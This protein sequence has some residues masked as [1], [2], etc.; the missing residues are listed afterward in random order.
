MCQIHGRALLLA[1]SHRL[2]LPAFP[3]NAGV[4]GYSSAGMTG[5][6]PIGTTI[7]V[8]SS[9]P[10]QPKRRRATATIPPVCEFLHLCMYVGQSAQQAPGHTWELCPCLSP[11]LKLH[12]CCPACASHAATDSE[13]AA[14]A[15]A[16]AARGGPAPASGADTT[17]A[18]S[19][20][21]AGGVA[22]GVVGVAADGKVGPSQGRKPKEQYAHR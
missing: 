18:G 7:I 11:C 5:V 21:V 2:N 19:A 16:A 20:G 14:A 10:G 1:N 9:A 3:D 12:L 17:A 15:A 8:T 4:S 13:V 22:V 6:P